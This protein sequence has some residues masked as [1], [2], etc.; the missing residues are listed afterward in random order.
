MKHKGN[1]I[2]LFVVFQGHHHMIYES[3]HVIIYKDGN[4]VKETYMKIHI[5]IKSVVS[6]LY[7]FLTS[8]NITHIDIKI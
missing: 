4:T 6:E 2:A 8:R 7:S 3:H 1:R 5:D